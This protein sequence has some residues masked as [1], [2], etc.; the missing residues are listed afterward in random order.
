[1][2][3]RMVVAKAEFAKSY[4]AQ[5]KISRL[6]IGILLLVM[7]DEVLVVVKDEAVRR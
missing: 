6:L 2:T 4:I 1:M 7:S 3:A 5:P